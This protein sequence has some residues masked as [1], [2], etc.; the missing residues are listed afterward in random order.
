MPHT[1]HSLPPWTC[2]S[3]CSLTRTAT[4]SVDDPNDPLFADVTVRQ[5][6]CT[7]KRSDLAS[8]LKH[9]ER[10]VVNLVFGE[11]IKCL[12]KLEQCACG[13]GECTS[14]VEDCALANLP[15]LGESVALKQFI[16]TQLPTWF[17]KYLSKVIPT[18]VP[19]LTMVVPAPFTGRVVVL[20]NL[21]TVSSARCH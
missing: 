15:T 1:P 17:S 10:G 12:D 7:K 14:C 2:R 8:F 16:T 20:R 4:Y 9:T 18:G 5:Q 19:Q 21:A 13:N 6:R 3:M 11:T